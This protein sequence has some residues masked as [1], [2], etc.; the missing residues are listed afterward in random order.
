MPRGAERHPDAHHAKPP[1]AKHH[2]HV[3]RRARPRRHPGDTGLGRSPDDATLV[4]PANGSTSTTAAPLLRVAA[5]DPDG[6][7]LQV[8]FQG[9]KAGA[10]VPGTPADPFTIVAIPDTQNYT[11]LNRQGTITQ[12]TQWA[13]STRSQLNTAFVVQLGDLVS[14]YDNLTQWGH[15]STA[16][17]VLDNAGLPNAVVPGNHDFN[18]ATGAITP[19]RHLL[20]AHPLLDRELDTVEHRLRRLPRPEPVRPRPGRPAQL[21]QLLPV[22]RGRAGLP[23][24]GSRVG[25]APVRPRL[26]GSGDRRPPHPDR[27]HVH[28]QLRERRR[29][30]SDDRRSVPAAP[31]PRRCGPTSSRRTARSSSC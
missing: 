27:D 13:V 15:T 4:A 8:T 29:H 2:R 9:R 24:A 1:F 22:H 31:P 23:R 12:Q 25:G 7:E 19:V 11:Y 14:E 18:N 30:P 5:S 17:S 28:P 26:G 6:G 10:T 3:R 21:R 16:F 20:P